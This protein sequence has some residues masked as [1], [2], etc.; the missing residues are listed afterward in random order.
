ML[1]KIGM[2]QPLKVHFFVYHAFNV[3]VYTNKLSGSCAIFLGN[4]DSF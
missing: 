4:Q 2:I 1:A 3:D